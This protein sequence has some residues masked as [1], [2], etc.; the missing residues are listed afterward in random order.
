MDPQL[1]NM[2]CLL[3]RG[4]QIPID[5]LTPGMGPKSFALFILVWV[6]TSLMTLVIP[7]L[8]GHPYIGAILF[9]IYF[10]GNLIY[11]VDTLSAECHTS[12]LGIFP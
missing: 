4:Y 7:S 6:G 1:A 9:V 5:T 12:F 3:N 2:V 11:I 10:F 8:L